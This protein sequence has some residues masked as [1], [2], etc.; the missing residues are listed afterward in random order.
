[1]INTTHFLLIEVEGESEE[2]EW[3]K[4]AFYYI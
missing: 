4:L 2:S 3:E 1:M